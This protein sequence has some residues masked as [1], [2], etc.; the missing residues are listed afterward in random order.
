M[1]QTIL[2]PT[3]SISCAFLLWSFVLRVSWRLP[4][5]ENMVWLC[6][7]QLIYSNRWKRNRLCHL[8]LELNQH[9]WL[10]P[11]FQLTDTWSLKRT[12]KAYWTL[13]KCFVH[14]GE[15]CKDCKQCSIRVHHHP[16]AVGDG[17]LLDCSKPVMGDGE[18]CSI[19]GWMPTT[20]LE[21]V[22]SRQSPSCPVLKKSS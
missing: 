22:S 9:Q 10:R 20:A 18:S 11:A 21:L 7:G 14:D 5:F 13:T 16:C 1:F 19:R 2:V 3:S 12:K 17:V 8:V 6:R 15:A 4:C